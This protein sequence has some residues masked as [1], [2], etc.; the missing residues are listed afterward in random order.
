MRKHQ[1]GSHDKSHSTQYHPP[2]PSWLSVTA[3]AP[4]ADALA[5]S[6]THLGASARLNVRESISSA[7]IA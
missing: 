1:S 6:T 4:F 7:K 5:P 2:G 3:I